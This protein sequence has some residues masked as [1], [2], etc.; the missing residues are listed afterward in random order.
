MTP[1]AAIIIGV[2]RLMVDKLL[3]G[4]AGVLTRPLDRARTRLEKNARRYDRDLRRRQ[5]RQH[6]RLKASGSDTR[7]PA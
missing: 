6:R 1:L 7:P 3:D 5:K 2:A 4:A